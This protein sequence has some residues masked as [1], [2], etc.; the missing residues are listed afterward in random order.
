MLVER[1]TVHAVV[2]ASISVRCKSHDET[3]KL[4]ICG[5]GND[6][7]VVPA[8]PPDA[9]RVTFLDAYQERSRWLT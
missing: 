7:I 4:C 3:F 1:S 9:L 5:H 2:D 6:E 8:V